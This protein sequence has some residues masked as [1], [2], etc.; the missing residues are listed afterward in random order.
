MLKRGRFATDIV[1]RRFGRLTVVGRAM[2]LPGGHARWRCRCVCGGETVSMGSKLHSGRAQSCG[3]LKREMMSA[4]A[5]VRFLKHGEC[6]GYETSKG[7]SAEAS[8]R[9]QASK[10]QRTPRWLTEDDLRV[11]RGQYEMAS[12]MSRLVGVP[13]SVDHVLPLQGREISG[14]HVPSNLRVIRASLNSAKGNRTDIR[15]ELCHL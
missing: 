13:Y 15:S 3:C 8:R 12:L 14:L 6:V 7:Y 4:A 10:M 1:G 11:M 2:N 9:R 5:K